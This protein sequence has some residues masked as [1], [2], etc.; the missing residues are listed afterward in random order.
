[1][2]MLEMDGENNIMTT[3]SSLLCRFLESN[4]VLIIMI[5]PSDIP[6]KHGFI[7]NICQY[8]VFANVCS[9]SVYM[10]DVHE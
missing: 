9:V 8:V 2:G 7:K 6:E 3:Q 10:H 1:M 4:C 5:V